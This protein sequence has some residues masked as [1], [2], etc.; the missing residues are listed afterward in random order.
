MSTSLLTVLEL[1]DEL[2]SPSRFDGVVIAAPAG[3]RDQPLRRA[4]LLDLRRGRRPFADATGPQHV[5][6]EV[7]QRVSQVFLQHRVV[8]ELGEAVKSI[9]T[10]IDIRPSLWT[11]FHASRDL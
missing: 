5:V 10:R 9:C 7:R 4:R 11:A 2:R 8:I 6:A 3:L 1:L